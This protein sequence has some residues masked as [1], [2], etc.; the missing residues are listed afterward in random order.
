MRRYGAGSWE[1]GTGGWGLD[2]G[3]WML[4]GYEVQAARYGIRD[5]EGITSF[6]HVA[7]EAS[8]FA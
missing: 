2:A 1:L 5:S 3:Y 6:A 7:P 8:G 4:D